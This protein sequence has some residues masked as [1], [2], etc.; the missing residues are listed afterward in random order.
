MTHRKFECPDG[1]GYG[2]FEVFFI[3]GQGANEPAFERGW[4]WWPVF[5]GCLPDGEM[6]G[7]FETEQQAIDDA[8]G[9]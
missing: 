1:G 9:F 5:P 7:P 3:T 6:C 8:Q 2:S 4:Y